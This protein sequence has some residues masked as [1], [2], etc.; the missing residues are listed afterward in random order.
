M[1]DDK[2]RAKAAEIFSQYLL[3]N[4][5]RDTCERR[6]ILDGAFSITGHFSIDELCKLLAD[7]DF[8][9]ARST[10]YATVELLVDC[11][12]LRGHNLRGGAVQYERKIGAGQHFHC[13]CTRCGRVRPVK[14]PEIARMLGYRR[15]PSFVVQ[16][17]ELYIY[18]QCHKCRA[19]K[20]SAE[21]SDKK[22]K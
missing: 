8:H 12:I 18:G 16:D 19:R 14:E 15:Y 11:G 2:S 1:N 3:S 4:N 20:P 6:A 5:L 22:V 17:I 13:V 9:V 10:V 21:K 7:S